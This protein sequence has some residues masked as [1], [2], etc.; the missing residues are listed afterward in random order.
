M[1]SFAPL[2]E[3][4]QLLAPAAA[5]PPAQNAAA[6]QSEPSTENVGALVLGLTMAELQPTQEKLAAELMPEILAGKVEISLQARGLIL[7]LK[8]S[9]F[10]APG[11]DSVAA[12][13]RPIFAQ[14][15]EALR[16][17]P[18]QV[19]LDGRTDNTPIHSRQFPSNWQLSTARGGRVA[20]AD[21]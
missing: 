16:R 7:S 18:G 5:K 20:V 11:D 6:P 13:A 12:D 19:R 17:V 15:A 3:T 8:E 10:F 14:V 9:A 4:F 1:R 2:R 21:E